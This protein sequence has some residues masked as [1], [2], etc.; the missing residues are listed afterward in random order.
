MP[1]Y[2]PWFALASMLPV[3]TFKPTDD[4]LFIAWYVTQHIFPSAILVLHGGSAERCK[5]TATP[6][7]LI[8]DELKQR[9][10]RTVPLSE[11]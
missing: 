5:Q 4:G 7:T 1:G 6:L 11:L 2:E 3:D 8:L 9:G 10:Y